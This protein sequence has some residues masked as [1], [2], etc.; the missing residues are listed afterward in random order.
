MRQ[1]PQILRTE[2]VSNSTMFEIEQ[3]D[4]RFANG[5]ERTFERICGLNRRAVMIV[6][7]L[8]NETVLLIRE[9]RVGTE[10]YEI[11]FP[12]GL[13]EHE[14]S[15]FDAANRELKEECG[16]GAKRFHCL[17][18]LSVAPSYLRSE[19]QV[20]VA[21]ELYEERLIGD[22]PETIEVFEWKINNIS[23]LIQQDE[24][25]ES[26]TVAAMYMTRE[27]IQQGE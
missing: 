11:S 17:K 6:P 5:V 14:E 10:R 24:F 25:S 3:V 22:E 27:F 7:L 9:Y 15:L 13:I 12:G 26:R 1:R 19:M 20:V 18:S 2:T 16:Y 21:S 4:L 23:E 8:D